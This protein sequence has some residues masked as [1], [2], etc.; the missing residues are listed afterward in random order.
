MKIRVKKK[1]GQHDRKV[2]DRGE[3][4]TISFKVKLRNKPVSDYFIQITSS[5]LKRQ[6]GYLITYM[7]R[8]ATWHPGR[9]RKLGPMWIRAGIPI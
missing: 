7:L 8:K 4:N 1:Q 9:N 3:S 2:Q 5:V 6:G